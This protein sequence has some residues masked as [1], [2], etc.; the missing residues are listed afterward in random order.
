MQ[1]FWVRTKANSNVLTLN[2]DMRSH[3]PATN[4][5]LKALAA[6]N[7]DNT[8]VR[9]QVSNGT[10]T[11]EAVIYFSANAANGRDPRHSA[12]GSGILAS[13]VNFRHNPHS[14]IRILC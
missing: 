3:A 9:L 10:N 4:K 7:V 13:V 6:R 11:D 1:A 2:K 5:S 12:F 14:L 8:L